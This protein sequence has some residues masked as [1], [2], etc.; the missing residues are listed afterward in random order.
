MTAISGFTDEQK[1]PKF[2]RNGIPLFAGNR[3]QRRAMAK[4][5]Y[6]KS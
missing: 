4:I 5:K 1:S 3:H 6:G 2:D